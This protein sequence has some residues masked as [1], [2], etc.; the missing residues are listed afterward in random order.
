[1]HFS[2]LVHF[3]DAVFDITKGNIFNCFVAEY[4]LV[5]AVSKRLQLL[6]PY[7]ICGVVRLGQHHLFANHRALALRKINA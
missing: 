6:H 4:N 2:H 5:D 1:M 7:R 3:C